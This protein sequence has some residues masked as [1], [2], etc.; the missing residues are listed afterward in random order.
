[1]GAGYPTPRPP[2]ATVLRTAKQRVRD[3][4]LERE[5]EKKADTGFK[6]LAERAAEEARRGS[7][8]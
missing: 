4:I 2:D 1:M 7:R 5:P 6:T 3:Q 8:V